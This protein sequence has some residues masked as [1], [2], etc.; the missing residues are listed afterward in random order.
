MIVPTGK[1]YL[2]AH[3]ASDGIQRRFGYNSW[4]TADEMYLLRVTPS[5]ENMEN[6]GAVCIS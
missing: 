3:G 5:I 2:V 6:G 4:I 1:A